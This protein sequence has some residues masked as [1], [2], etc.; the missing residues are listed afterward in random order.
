MMV[1][2]TVTRSGQKDEMLMFDSLKP[3]SSLGFFKD[4][5]ENKTKISFQNI[6]ITHNG[7]P[8][9]GKDDAKL[10]DLIFIDSRGTSRSVGSRGRQQNSTTSYGCLW[11]RDRHI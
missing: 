5:L 9:L 6:A 11:C 1:H 8:L 7:E 10:N 3:A 4:I 2:V